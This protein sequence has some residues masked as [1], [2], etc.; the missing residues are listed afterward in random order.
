MNVKELREKLTKYSD[1]LRIDD[2]IAELLEDWFA[3]LEEIKRRE[4]K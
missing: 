4:V 3:Y 2:S 1:D